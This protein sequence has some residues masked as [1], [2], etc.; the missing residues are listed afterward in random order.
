MIG[1]LATGTLPVVVVLI[2]PVETRLR[3]TPG[4]AAVAVAAKPALPVGLAP[5][6]VDEVPDATTGLVVRFPVIL[7]I[8]GVGRDERE[9]AR[10]RA[11]SGLIV[12]EEAGLSRVE[13]LD[14]AEG[15][16]G[17][18]TV[19]DE[20]VVGVTRVALV[21]VDDFAGG[22]GGSAALRGGPREARTP[23]ARAGT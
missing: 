20:E 17:L 19:A 3:A 16:A 14:R 10:P 5:A 22:G 11:E 12:S 1:A 23:A 7:V 18:G 4:G 15:T 6:L 8:A 9:P 21:V 2:G 13:T